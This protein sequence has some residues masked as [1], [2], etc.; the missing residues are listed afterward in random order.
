[1]LARLPGFLRGSI[2][3]E[4]AR[5]ALARRLAK[6]DAT[7][8]DV[9]RRTI[10]ARPGSPYGRL[11]RHAG[12]ESGDLERLV[13]R[14]GVEGAL[15]AILAAGVYLTVA[16]LR[17][18][19][20]ARRGSL[21][22]EVDPGQ[23]GNPLVGWDLPMRTGGTGSPGLSF[24]WNLAF[25]RDRAVDLC[26]VEAALGPGCRRHAVWTPP[27]SGAI[28][29]L[30]DLCARGSAPARWFSPVDPAVREL[31]AR[32]R[33]SIRLA[34]EGGRLSG[35]RLP[36]PE[37]V[38]ALAPDPVVGWMADTLAAG[39]TPRLHARPSAVLRACEAAARHGVTLDGAEVTVD[40]EPITGPRALAMRRAGLRV[41]PRYAAAEVGQIGAACLTPLGSDD[42]HVLHDLVAVIQATGPTTGC[43]PAGAFLVSSL[44]P[45][46][47]LILLNASMG[48]TGVLDDRPCGCPVSAPG[49]TIRAR[50][51]QRIDALADDGPSLPFAAVARALDET[52]PR[53]FGGGPGDY[54]LVED[55]AAG[56]ARRLRL[57]VH[58]GVG[59]LDP[60]AVAEAFVAGL[61]GWSSGRLP[62]VE[63]HAPL[64]TDV[65]KVLHVHRT[66]AGRER[67]E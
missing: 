14:D 12:C 39:A 44:R 51:I 37:H 42:V 28:V 67:H 13:Q 43:L 5:P 36:A 24:G 2:D 9:V 49:W 15:Q 4:Q 66:R 55:E 41:L 1:L 61:E 20:P 8:L 22:L 21:V 38:P 60:R 56:G 33:W 65:G 54:Q 63:R 59:L 23:L 31:P 46:A 17:G 25:V 19:R 35:R 6:R 26:V 40:G 50:G 30:L 52:L 16:E 18:E 32:Y 34:R 58:P 29:H 27:G 62:A 48:D 7:F 45:T 11:L 47:P 3:P 10:Y 57:L 53:R 64:A